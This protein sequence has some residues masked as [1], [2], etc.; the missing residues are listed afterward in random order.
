MVQVSMPAL[1]LSNKTL[2]VLRDLK[3]AFVLNAE[4][5]RENN[6][7]KNQTLFLQSKINVL[8]EYEIE[9]R[10]LRALLEFKEN[11]EYDTIPAKVIGRDLTGWSQIIIIDKGT[12]HNI[13]IDMSV[14]S[15]D[16]VVGKVIETGYFASKVLLLIDKQ[17]RIGAIMQK[18]RF[19][20][21]IEGTGKPYLIMN[22]LPREGDFFIDD[23]ALSSGLGKVYEK[24]L[25]IGQIKAIHEEKF[26]LYKYAEVVPAVNFNKLEEVLVILKSNAEFKKN[27]ARIYNLE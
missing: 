22:Y 15:G 14:V 25:V 24:G 26:G 16:G 1:S 6:A 27:E 9:N 4:L 5:K 13:A 20:G 2:T 11:I 12:R 8:R 10:R 7:L 17:S 3:S 21:V 18:S 23:M 19:V